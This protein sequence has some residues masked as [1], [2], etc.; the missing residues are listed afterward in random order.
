MQQDKI[1]RTL[2]HWRLF[3]IGETFFTLVFKEVKKMKIKVFLNFF[4]G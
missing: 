1:I 4:A 2:V 3:L